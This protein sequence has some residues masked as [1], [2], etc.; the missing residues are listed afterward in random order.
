MTSS[1]MWKGGNCLRSKSLTLSGTRL[2]L[3]ILLLTVFLHFF[4]LPAVEKYLKQDVMVVETKKDTNKVPL[5]A[6]TISGLV[7][8]EVPCF[9]QNL[10]TSCIKANTHNLSANLKGLLLGFEKK[11]VISLNNKVVSED[12]TAVWAG[13]QFT[14]NLALEVGP[15]YLNDQ[16]IL[17]LAPGFVRIYLHDPKFFIFNLN[18]A[19]PP[20][21]RIQL[22]VKANGSSLL[23]MIGLTEME[24]LDLPADPCKEEHSYNFNSCVR[25][26]VAKQVG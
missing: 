3:Q 20:A 23:G 5:P 14:L 10:S 24:E 13:R 26:S 6:I 17:L 2:I 22:D 21:E 8:P 18:A 4:G 25:M 19:G 12:F 15:D 11:Q 1:Q 9:T 16:L 7:D